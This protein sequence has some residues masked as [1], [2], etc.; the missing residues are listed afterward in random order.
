MKYGPIKRTIYFVQA[1][2]GGPIKIGI[3]AEPERRVH[4]MQA[5]CPVK[6]VILA[7]RSGTYFEEQSLHDRLDKHR[8]HG[9]WFEDCDEVRAAVKNSEAYED[10]APEKP[11]R[12]RLTES[13]IRRIVREELAKAAA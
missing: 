2:D 9:E 1:V 3:A 6:L 11:I 8:L 4:E 7:T 10:D 5:C 13:Q 12:L